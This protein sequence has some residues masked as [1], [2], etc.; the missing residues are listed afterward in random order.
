MLVGS[1]DIACRVGLKQLR[2][3]NEWLRCH[4]DFPK[5]LEIVSGV[6]MLDWPDNERWVQKTG[7]RDG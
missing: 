5:P 7:R 3:L 1:A 2:V 6:L 4:P